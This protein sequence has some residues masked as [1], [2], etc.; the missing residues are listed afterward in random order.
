MLEIYPIEKL[1]Q[2]HKDLCT[3]VFI[4]IPFTLEKMETV[5]MSI[6]KQ[7]RKYAIVHYLKKK[8]DKSTCT[9]MAHV[10]QISE[11]SLKIV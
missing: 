7:L 4:A 2:M 6:I 1:L 3:K 9:H 10:V 5:Q 8:L 11:E